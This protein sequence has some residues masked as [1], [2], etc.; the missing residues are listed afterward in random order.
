MADIEE[1]DV[2]LAHDPGHVVAVPVHDLDHVTVAVDVTALLDRREADHPGLREVIRGP[3]PVHVA[4]L[5]QASAAHRRIIRIQVY[6]RRPKLFYPHQNP[7]Y[8]HLLVLNFLVKLLKVLPLLLQTMVPIKQ[9]KLVL[10]QVIIIYPI[11]LIQII[12]HK[13]AKFLH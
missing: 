1:G 2:A 10:Y 9:I 12:L 5:A 4:D 6:N 11:I 3:V 7:F 8:P 13:L